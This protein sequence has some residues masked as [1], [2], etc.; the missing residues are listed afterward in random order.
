M[1][2][3]VVSSFAAGW[4]TFSHFTGAAAFLPLSPPPLLI[5]TTIAMTMNGARTNAKLRIER[6]RRR[7]LWSCSSNSRRASRFWR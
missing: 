5:A 7:R 2:A 3:V 1:G 4:V 6:I